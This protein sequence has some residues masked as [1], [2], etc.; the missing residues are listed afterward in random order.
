MTRDLVLLSLLLF[1]ISLPLA[2]PF[3]AGAQEQISAD[4]TAVRQLIDRY[5]DRLGG[6]PECYEVA[7][8]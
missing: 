5:L 6:S 4:E 1:L 7:E 2:S 8:E 3:G